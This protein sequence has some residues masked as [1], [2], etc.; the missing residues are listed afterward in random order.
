[1]QLE[2][3]GFAIEMSRSLHVAGLGLEN[4]AYEN[5]MGKNVPAYQRLLGTHCLEKRPTNQEK[6]EEEGQ[7]REPGRFPG[8]H[9]A[10]YAKAAVARV[11]RIPKPT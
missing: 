10:E 4:V 1:M 6:Y 11:Y 9:A 7:R 8:Y 3:R 5:S 2:I